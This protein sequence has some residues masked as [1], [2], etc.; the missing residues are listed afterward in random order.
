MTT[1]DNSAQI[2]FWNERPGRSWARH[3]DSVDAMF[4]GLTE[5]VLE[6]AAP[7]A[8]DRVLDLGCG[9]GGLAIPF[10][11]RVPGG[12]V[13]GIDVSEPMIAVARRRAAEAGADVR[14][15]VGDAVECPLEPGSFDLLVSR[16]GAMFFADPVLAFGS[17]RRALAPRGRIVLCVWREPRDNAWAMVPVSAAR[18]FVEIP[19]RS[20]PEDPGPF[21]FADPGRVRR[22]L[23]GA[24]FAAP[25]CAPLDLD[26]PISDDLERAVEF[27]V[28]VGPLATPYFMAD[29][30]NRRRARDAVAAAL[31]KN[32]RDGA[33]RL[34]GG[35]WIVTAD[36]P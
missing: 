33:F 21:S 31:E 20:A 6:A 35:C 2:E 27:T 17:L 5:A 29:E 28:E 13:T 3:S 8:G 25:S 11:G 24:G 16:L 34:G 10:A 23:E 30:A 9:A 4:A 36:A 15:V 18:A 14:F 1:L 26:M 12:A 19:P 32:W 7:A 22:I